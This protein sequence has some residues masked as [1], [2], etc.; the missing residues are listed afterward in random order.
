M[1][2]LFKSQRFQNNEVSPDD[3]EDEEDDG[4]QNLLSEIQGLEE[5]LTELE[6]ELTATE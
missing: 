2:C 6:I 1:L 3:D 4:L 5:E